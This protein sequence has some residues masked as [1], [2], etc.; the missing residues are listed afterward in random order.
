[1]YVNQPKREVEAEF[2]FFGYEF[3]KEKIPFDQVSKERFT[4]GAIAKDF[5]VESI[6]KLLQKDR[7]AT[8]R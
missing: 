2:R 5:D 8:N 6:E 1:M 4:A 7:E 3:E